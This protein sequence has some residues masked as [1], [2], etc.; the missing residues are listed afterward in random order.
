M[1][2]VQYS[3]ALSTERVVG[4]L[5]YNTRVRRS[6]CDDDDLKKTSFAITIQVRRRLARPWP[7][8]AI[9]SMVGI[10]PR[11]PLGRVGEKWNDIQN[12]IVRVQI[13]ESW[14]IPLSVIL[15]LIQI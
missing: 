5:P 11:C 12:G 9:Y 14:T 1:V 15:N 10:R 13:T 6:I 7:A 4:D 8:S 2:S 3:P